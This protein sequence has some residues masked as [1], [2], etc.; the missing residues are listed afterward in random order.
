L[1]SSDKNIVTVDKNG[2][3]T[4]KKNGTVKISVKTSNGRP[5]Q[6]LLQLKMIIRM[7]KKKQQ[8]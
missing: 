1:S 5:I 2:K 3:I 6:S 7:K 8:L 4:A